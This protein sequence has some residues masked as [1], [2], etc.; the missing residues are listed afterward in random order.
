MISKYEFMLTVRVFRVQKSGHTF[1]RLS[2]PSIAGVITTAVS[3]TEATLNARDG[4]LGA[5]RLAFPTNQ[6]MRLDVRVL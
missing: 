6:F 2:P 3:R 1:K 5:T 4:L